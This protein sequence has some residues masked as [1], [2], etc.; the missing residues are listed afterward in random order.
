MVAGLPFVDLLFVGLLV[1]VLQRVVV[2]LI[3]D[4]LCFSLVYGCSM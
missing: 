3:F 4:L 2:S 1:L